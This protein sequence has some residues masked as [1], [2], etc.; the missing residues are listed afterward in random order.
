MG[1]ERLRASKL[2]LDEINANSSKIPEIMEK[3]EDR[4]RRITI[5]L[6]NEI[7]DKVQEK[8]RQGISQTALINAALKN[9]LDKTVDD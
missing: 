3:F 2:K 9:L 6:E 5:Y 8:R 1:I 7:Y 4:Y